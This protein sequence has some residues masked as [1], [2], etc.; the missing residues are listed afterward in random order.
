MFGSGTFEKKQ[1][2]DFG[3]E[4]FD[5]RGRYI[6]IEFL[7]EPFG[8]GFRIGVAVELP[9]QEIFRF[10]Q[11]KIAQ[12]DR[13]LECEMFLIVDDLF[14]DNQIIAQFWRTSII[15]HDGNLHDCHA[16]GKKIS[17]VN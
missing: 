3:G 10:S 9:D 11:A 7:A 8:D 13:I 12:S 5:R 16:G 6:E 4:L 17:I 2:I 14:G 1:R 15:D